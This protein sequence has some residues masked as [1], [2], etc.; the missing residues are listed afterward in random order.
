MYFSSFFYLCNPSSYLHLYLF[1]E[2]NCH[3]VIKLFPFVGLTQ[4]QW[5]EKQ[6]EAQYVQKELA[7]FSSSCVVVLL[8]CWSLNTISC[9]QLIVATIHL[10]S[11]DVF[12]IDQ[13]Q[14]QSYNSLEI[15]K[16]N[17]KLV[18]TTANCF[19]R[20]I[21]LMDFRKMNLT[22]QKNPLEIL[23]ILSQYELK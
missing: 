18:I 13:F 2:K 17:L 21:F 3:L 23:Y 20:Q 16:G 11:L 22:S 10:M 12:S 8:K 5:K 19:M 6:F 1:L 14:Y 15:L 4:I 9:L 7:L